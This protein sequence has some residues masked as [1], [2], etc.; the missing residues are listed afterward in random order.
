MIGSYF[1]GEGSALMRSTRDTSMM[2]GT[3]ES[4]APLGA[5]VCDV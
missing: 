3:Q 1:A 2:R 5:Q 4:Y